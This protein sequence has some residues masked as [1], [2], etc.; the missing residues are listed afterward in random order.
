M[1]T[2]VHNPSTSATA[3]SPPLG[4]VTNPPDVAVSTAIR[5]VGVV[6]HTGLPG[7]AG[8]G[9]DIWEYQMLTP[10]TT[11]TIDHDLGRNPVA[12]QVVIDGEEVSEFGVYFTIENEQVQ[13]SFDIPAA[14]LIRLL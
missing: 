9:V 4:A 13:I 11:A 14:A 7:P 8:T 12:V 10:A 2:I 3:V 5:N 6:V 1:T